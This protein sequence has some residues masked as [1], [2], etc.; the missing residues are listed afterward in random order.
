MFVF[1]DGVAYPRAGSGSMGSWVNRVRL[2]VQGE[3][4]WV[5]CPVGCQMRLGAPMNAATIDDPC[6]A[7]LAAEAIEDLADQ[8]RRGGAFQG[9]DGPP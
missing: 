2:L 7:W 4:R 5:T 3:P 9:Y 1:L 8:L 6:T